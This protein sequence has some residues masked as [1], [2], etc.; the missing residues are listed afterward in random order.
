MVNKNYQV[1]GNENMFGLQRV[2]D[3]GQFTYFLTDRQ[4]QAEHLCR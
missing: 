2:F 3:D 1:S 4:A